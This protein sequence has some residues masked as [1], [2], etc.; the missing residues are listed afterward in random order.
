MKCYD[1]AKKIKKNYVAQ[2]STENMKNNTYKKI[3]F[4]SSLILGNC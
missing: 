1:N 4:H 3:F 2:I